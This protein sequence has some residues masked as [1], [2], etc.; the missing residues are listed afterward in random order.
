MLVMYNIL[1]VQ[2]LYVNIRA[3]LPRLLRWGFILFLYYIVASIVLD[4]F[5]QRFE[6]CTNNH[7]RNGF[8]DM[9]GTTATRPWAYRILIPTIVNIITYAIP[10]SFIYNHRD[11]LKTQSSVLKYRKEVSPDWNETLGLKYHIT[12]YIIFIMLFLTIFCARYSL[13]LFFNCKTFVSD[14]APPIA[15]LFLPL[16]FVEGGYMYDFFELFISVVVLI[17]LKKN[18]LWTYYILFPLVILNKESDILIITYFIINQWKQQSKGNLLIHFL[19]QIIIGVS[20]ILGIR[21]VFIDRGGAP[22]EFNFWENI[23]WYADPMCYVRFMGGFANTMILPRT[24]NI[25]NVILLSFSV[26]Y[27]WHDKP[28]ELKRTLLYL[29]AIYIPL[30]IVSGWHD[31]IRI[32][33]LTYILVFLLVCHT[34]ISIYN[35]FE[36]Y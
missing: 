6:F 35:S 10:E 8:E 31:E 7:N 34:F 3:A 11:F 27:K 5:M 17:C 24:F 23:N 28:I 32:F 9:V 22:M 20:I 29:L 13:M 14:L 33:G 30:F 26:F 16:T 36:N 15:L 12:Y 25:I 21:T 19:V 4:T 1:F 2:L 18:M